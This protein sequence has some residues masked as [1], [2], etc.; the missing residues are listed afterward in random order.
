MAF[1][2][3]ESR[4]GIEGIP[5]SRER[6]RLETPRQNHEALCGHFREE[7][8]GEIQPEYSIHGH[9]SQFD[10]VRLQPESSLRLIPRAELHKRFTKENLPIPG[11][12]VAVLLHY[13][14]AGEDEEAIKYTKLCLSSLEKI[15]YSDF[16]I[17]IVDSGSTDGFYSQYR[18]GFQEEFPDLKK[19]TLIRIEENVGCAEGYNVGVERALKNGAEYIFLLNN[20]TVVLNSDILT[21]LVGTMEEFPGVAAVGPKVYYWED[22]QDTP[23]RFQFIGGKFSFRGIGVGRIDRGQF[24]KVIPVDFLSGAAMLMKAEAIYEVGLFDPRFFIYL[25][26]LDW[27]ARAKEAGYRFLYVP[28]GQVRHRG[29]YSIKRRFNPPYIVDGARNYMYLIKSHSGRQRAE[30]ALR[31]LSVIGKSVFGSLVVNRDFAS[32]NE[33]VKG[34]YDG[35]VM[36]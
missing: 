34:I 4:D 19:T 27:A 35:L 14:R 30:F 23:E 29:R 6:W 21:N 2:E 8:E 1:K 22:R 17:V 9:F 33:I 5:V 13:G 26:E 28:G 20:D 15:A 3:R 10:F 16:E 11:K 18:S 12:I 25:E 36:S 24:E 7:R 32:F 31:A